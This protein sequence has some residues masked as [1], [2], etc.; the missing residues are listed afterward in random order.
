MKIALHGLALKAEYIADIE[1]LFRELKKHQ[2]EI[3]VTEPL[4][5]ALKMSGNRT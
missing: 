3:L 4:D 1:I 2:I 5:R